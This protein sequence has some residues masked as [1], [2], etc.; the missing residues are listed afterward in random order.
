LSLTSHPSHCRYYSSLQATGDISEGGNSPASPELATCSDAILTA[1]AQTGVYQTG[2]DRALISLFDAD[3]QHIIAEATASTRLQP[4]VKSSE[5]DSLWLCGCAIPRK[6][7]VCEYTLLD[8]DVLTGQ[9][10]DTL[11]DDDSRE[12]P[13]TISDD[14]VADP[15]FK[16]RPYCQPGTLCRFYAA[17]PIRTRRGVNIGVYCVINETP[18]KEWN[19]DLTQRLR[20]VSRNIM[21]HL[22]SKRL[23]VLYR[24]NSRMNRGMGSFVEG[25]STISGLPPAPCGPALTDESAFEGALNAQQQA[26]LPEDSIENGETGMQTPT[27]PVD[28]E[29]PAKNVE[30]TSSAVPGNKDDSKSS[31]ADSNAQDDN[32]PTTV[33]SRAANLLRESMEVEGCVFVDATMEAYRA[34]TQTPSANAML[35]QSATSSSDDSFEHSSS[36]QIIRHSTVM[37]FSTSVKSSINGDAQGLFSSSLPE[38]FLAKLLRRY[39]NGKIFNF[40]AD[41]VLQSS[42][43]SDDDLTATLNAKESPIRKVNGGLP[44]RPS[45]KLPSKPWARQREG[46]ILAKAFPGARCVAF[47]PVWDPRKDRWYAGGFVYTNAPSR[48]FTEEDELSYLRAFGMLTMAEILRT[49]DL[50]ADKAKS[51]VLGSLSHELRSPL[52]GVI[53]SAEL[54][55]ETKL[56]VFQG[57]AAHTIEICSRTLLDTIDHLLD[58]SKINSFSRKK[59]DAKDKKGKPRGAS[60]TVAALDDAGQH[61]EKS[62]TCISQLDAL[63]EEVIE[64][65]FAGYTFQFLSV[66]QPPAKQPEPAPAKSVD[67]RSSI[68]IRTVADFDP[69]PTEMAKLSQEF[70]DLSVIL[71]IDPR[72]NWS[73]FVQVGAIRRI[74]MNIFGNALKYTSKGTIKVALTQ[75]VASIHHRKKERVVRFTVQDT[76][77]GIGA[78]FLQNGLFRPFSQEDTLTPGTGLGLSLVKRIVLELRG[79]VSIQSQ[80][81]VGTTVNIVLPLEQVSNS[82]ERALL[83]SDGNKMFTD[84]VHDLKGLRV[85]LALS[86][87]YRDSTGSD[88]HNAVQSIC[89]DWLTM[90]VVSNTSSATTP[91]L[92][93]W[94][95]DA[96]PDSSKDL[97]ALA[98]TPNVVLCP[99]ALVAYNH[100][101]AF[102]AADHAAIFEFISQPCVLRV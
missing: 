102:E 6:H 69:L 48:H 91:D 26:L 20:D 22:E 9:A 59:I 31:A 96:L 80:V 74:V 95:H 101:T 4:S 45:G 34:P 15:R 40:G 99:N 13:L 12:L 52:H 57:N 21:S 16:S 8:D 29:P 36:G 23:E 5:S 42:D 60:K 44:G 30:Q 71:S 27:A 39:P 94:S 37:A 84:Q 18:G 54:L 67:R 81:G 3:Y 33:L 53:L 68:S 58:Y 85:G 73:Y 17:V 93:L 55:A 43:S 83:G 90:E 76:G 82:P 1:L 75:E 49:M 92:M 28:Q 47:T 11:D 72:Q 78:D 51:D 63:I 10:T 97:K 56:S 66:S 86:K 7:G 2:T 100:S 89:N 38:K 25:E 46:S 24:R 61:G 14:L 64:S 19:D 50:Q 70:G 32:N 98:K 41:G 35:E 87:Q 65:V 79:D 62:L 77:K 88:W